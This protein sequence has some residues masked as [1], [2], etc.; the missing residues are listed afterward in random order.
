MGKR[1]RLH[2]WRIQRIRADLQPQY[3][4]NEENVGNSQG[5]ARISQLLRVLW[6]VQTQSILYRSYWICCKRKEKKQKIG[7]MDTFPTPLILSPWFS[8]IAIHDQQGTNRPV[9][10][11]IVNFHFEM[12]RSKPRLNLRHLHFF[13]HET[14]YA[15]WRAK[16][17]EVLLFLDLNPSRREASRGF[18]ATEMIWKFQPITCNL[19]SKLS[20]RIELEIKKPTFTKSFNFKTWITQEPPF[21]C[22]PLFLF[23]NLQQ[24]LW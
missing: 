10:A 11:R 15:N 2:N 4:I 7:R 12:K 17:K 20:T 13:E 3:K 22:N 6:A 1:L 8:C 21:E 14:A 16:N 23:T 24:L 9:Y 19:S 5:H 18:F